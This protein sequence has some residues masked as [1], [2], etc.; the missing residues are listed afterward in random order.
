MI[1]AG[2]HEEMEDK[3]CFFYSG[4]CTKIQGI[5]D[6]KESNTINR[7]FHLA[8]LVKKEL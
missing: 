6:Y 8:M 4:L 3:I 7:L 5:V 2:I 1:R